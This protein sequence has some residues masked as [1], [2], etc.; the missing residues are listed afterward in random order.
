M[1]EV[2]WE[3]WKREVDIVLQSKAEEWHIFGYGRVSKDDVW[4][5]F[6]AKLPRLDVPDRIRYHWIVAQ[7]FHLQANDYMNWLTLQ[8]YKGPNLFSEGDPLHSLL[9]KKDKNGQKA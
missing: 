9:N 6:I 7:L 3:D 5:C 4:D 1:D 8:A 2:K